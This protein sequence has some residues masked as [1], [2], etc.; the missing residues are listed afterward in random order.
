M[1]I[2]IT[3]ENDISG[4][5]GGDNNQKII[6]VSSE[7]TLEQDE[8]IVINIVKDYIDCEDIGGWYSWE[9]L[10]PEFFPTLDQE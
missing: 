3:C 8:A 2:L 10:H 5:A 6:K 9:Y 7:N 1:L 4:Q